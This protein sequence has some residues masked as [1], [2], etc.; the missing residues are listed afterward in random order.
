MSNKTNNKFLSIKILSLFILGLFLLSST[1]CHRKGCTDPKANNYDSKSKKDDNSCN[2]DRDKLIGSYYMLEDCNGEFNYSL[3]ISEK[4]DDA[5]YVLLNNIGGW[6]INVSIPA[7]VDGDNLSFDD[8]Y[9]GFHFQGTGTYDS[10][11][12]KLTLEYQSWDANNE[13]ISSCTSSGTKQ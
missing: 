6:T 10:A 5:S 4:T 8:H 12:K 11:T 9:E 3:T 13:P 7:L 2:Y 1:S